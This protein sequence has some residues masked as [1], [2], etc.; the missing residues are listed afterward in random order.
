M[1]DGPW[2]RRRAALT[3]GQLMQVQQVVTSVSVTAAGH[4]S[5]AT[6]G[7]IDFFYKWQ[8]N[9]NLFSEC[10]QMAI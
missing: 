6:E 2:E 8:F 4:D 10:G 5:V 3:R 9:L 1:I 7:N